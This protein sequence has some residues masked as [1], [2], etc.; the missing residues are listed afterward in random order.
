[1]SLHVH[2]SAG[3]NWDFGPIMPKITNPCK[4]HGGYPVPGCFVGGEKMP[5][6]AAVFELRVHCSDSD[7]EFYLS[8]FS[9]SEWN[10]KNP[11]KSADT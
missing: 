11:K 2:P 5:H 7:C 8:E 10:E 1:M 4:H 9:T 3:G 6:G